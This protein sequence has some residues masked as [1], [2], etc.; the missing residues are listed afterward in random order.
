MGHE[1]RDAGEVAGADAGGQQGLVGVTEGG[2]GQEQPPVPPQRPSK[3]PGALPLQ[4]RPQP[5]GGIA[6]GAQ[7]GHGVTKWGGEQGKEGG[8]RGWHWGRQG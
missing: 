3:A 7:G 5:L 4:H 6:W 1:G 2:V 8:D